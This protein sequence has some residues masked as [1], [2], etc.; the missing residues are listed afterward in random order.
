[1][2]RDMFPI[3]QQEIDDFKRRINLTEYAAA[4]GYV[5][6]RKE[7]SRNSVTMRGPDGD[8][9]IIGKDANSGHWL[10]FSVRNDADNGTIIDFVQNRLQEGLGEVRKALRPWVGSSPQ[11]PRRPASESFVGDVEPISRD[12]A[13]IRAQFA[14]MQPVQGVHPYLER[15]RCIPAAVLADPR[16][17]GRIYTDCHG[18]AVFPHH[19]RDGL[20]GFELRNSRFKGFAKGGQ[21]GLWYSAHGPDDRNLVITESAIEALSYHAIHKPEGT[22]YFSIAG[23]MNPTQRQLLESAFLKLPPDAAIRIATNHDAGGRHLAEQ[24][25]AIALATGR[26]NLALID[27]Q[28][29]REGADWNDMLRAAGPGPGPATDSAPKLVLQR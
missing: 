13:R 29:E 12:L 18:N 24:I 2:V 10:Y 6:D 14:A 17:V 16:F 1:M 28:P 3:R 26:T 27:S 23:E 22:R 7:S 9:I 21:K 8:K 5:L 20:C 11:S 25:K 4:Q 19:D 15:E